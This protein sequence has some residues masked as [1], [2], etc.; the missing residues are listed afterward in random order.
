MTASPRFITKEIALLLHARSIEEHGGSHSLRDKGG[1]E[2][3]LT[4]A[5][6][7]YL[8]E[9]AS[10]AVCAA[11]YAYHLTK[12]HAFIDGNKRIAAAVAETFLE[13]NGLW[14][15]ATNDEIVDLFLTIAAN[16]CTREEGEAFFQ[17][18]TE[19]P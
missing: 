2:S 4:A 17:Q 18:K 5:E 19:T 13:W 16:Q 12:A 7:R 8:Y 11:T 10:L 3:T 6:N 9:E 14:L 15:D 1:F